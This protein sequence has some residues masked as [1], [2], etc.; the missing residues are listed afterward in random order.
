MLT[1][2]GIGRQKMV[3]EKNMKKKER[4]KDSRIWCSI[5]EC[6]MCFF[7]QNAILSILTFDF[8]YFNC[9]QISETPCII[10][11]NE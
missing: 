6:F 2:Q 11:C 7:M 1:K 9:F 8:S 5:H 4:K 10:V 3:L